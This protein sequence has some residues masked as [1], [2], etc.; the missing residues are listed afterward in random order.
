MT[1]YVSCLK[2]FSIPINTFSPNWCFKPSRLKKKI[3]R[4]FKFSSATPHIPITSSF[5]SAL[6]HSPTKNGARVLDS[7][8][9]SHAR[10]PA[11]HTGGVANGAR[12]FSF[13]R[14][15]FAARR[16]TEYIRE[17]FKSDN[18]FPAHTRSAGYQRLFEIDVVP[19]FFSGDELDLRSGARS[20][21]AEFFSK[22]FER[23]WSGHSCKRSIRIEL[24]LSSEAPCDLK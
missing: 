20:S 17:D 15:N 16:Y 8:K 5:I 24:I 7:R 14:Q 12:G 23:W 4:H 22:P 9:L 10:L 21:I 11:K 13:F 6:P 18:F 19:L 2:A 1:A 3:M